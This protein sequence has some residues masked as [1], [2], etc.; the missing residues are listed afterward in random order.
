MKGSLLHQNPIFYFVSVLTDGLRMM[1]LPKRLL[2]C[3]KMIRVLDFWKGLPKSKNPPGRG[4]HGKNRTYEFLLS[5]M[6]GPLVPV[7]LR[8]FEETAKKLN[9]FAVTFQT[10]SPMAPFIVDSLENLVHSFVERFILPDLLKKANTTHKLG[11]LDMT[12]PNIQ[13]KT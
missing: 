3:P 2:I 11:Q 12:D 9:N 5:Q 10:S 13:M 1:L 6:N 4:G 8:F 7:K